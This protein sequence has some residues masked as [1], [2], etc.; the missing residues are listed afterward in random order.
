[1]AY[2]IRNSFDIPLAGAPKPTLEEIACG[3]E[4]TVSVGDYTNYKFS[5]LVQEGDAVK[6][7]TPILAVK[8]D[9]SIT[10]SSPAAGK[11][12]TILRGA[13]RRLLGIVV[14]VENTNDAEDFG[15]WKSSKVESASRKEIIEQIK[16]GGLW[17]FLTQRP[18]QVLADASV[19]PK[20]IF[21]NG[22]E[23]APLAPSQEFLVS[24][25]SEEF[26]LGLS[27]VAKLAEKAFLAVHRDCKEPSLSNAKG[28]QIEQFF[29]DHPAGLVGTHINR[30]S[31][32]SKGDSIWSISAYEVALIGE[33]LATGKTPSEQII[34]VGGE[35]ASRNGYFKIVRGTSISK[36]IELVDTDRLIEGTP[37]FGEKR[38]TDD[39]T[40]YKP[41]SLCVVPET[42]EQYY[43]G[44]D[45]HWAGPG[46]TRFSLWNFFGST[47]L[48]KKKWNLDTNQYGEH[49]AILLQDFLEQYIDHDIYLT[50]LIKAC[51]AEDID[52]ME[53]LGLYELAPEDVALPTFLCPSK[54][55][56]VSIIADGLELLRKEA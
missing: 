25:K 12:K 44:E 3:N 34:S 43:L 55:D 46:F 33:L 48:K 27:A 47:L 28:V 41:S 16:K 13:R 10:L 40:S 36:I 21:I 19:T 37:L 54:T 22:M 49:R 35:N 4:V 50:H 31:P 51:L 9:D 53:K 39:V 7:G 2:Q 15:T 6:V 14:E 42:Q 18:F 20:A 32:I 11:I 56:A 24:Q 26:A 30:L 5:N 1:M 45:R 29:G 17:S 52:M 23:T 38:S 8:G